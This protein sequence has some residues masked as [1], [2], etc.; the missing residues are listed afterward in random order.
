[1]GDESEKPKVK[2]RILKDWIWS[3]MFEPVQYERDLSVQYFRQTCWHA[4]ILSI[5]AGWISCLASWN[6]FPRSLRLFLLSSSCCGRC[7]LFIPCTRRKFKLSIPVLRIQSTIIFDL[8]Q[9]L[10][11]AAYT[12]EY[13]TVCIALDMYRVQVIRGGWGLTLTNAK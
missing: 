12:R 1:M 5:S 11:N 6:M 8:H 3:V 7:Y 10:C 13:N 2:R 9:I 4:R